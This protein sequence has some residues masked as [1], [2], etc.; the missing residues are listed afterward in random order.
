MI[1]DVDGN[2]QD[3]L[4]ACNK[5]HIVATT[6]ATGKELLR[7]EF[8]NVQSRLIG[9]SKDS[10]QIELVGDTEGGSQGSVSSSR[11]LNLLDIKTLKPNWS[12][13]L[14][15]QATHGTFIEPLRSTEAT[16]SEPVEPPLVS[17]NNI[18]LLQSTLIVPQTSDYRGEQVVAIPKPNPTAGLLAAEDPRW[19]ERVPWSSTTDAM[20]GRGNADRF[21]GYLLQSLIVCL[22]AV[23]F[24][25][26]FLRRML[27]RKRWS[28]KELFLF[29]LLFAVPYAVL[30]L[31]LASFHFNFSN[32]LAEGYGMRVVAARMLASLFVLPTVVFC[33]FCLK[34]LWRG[35]WR[36][37][38]M[39]SLI[40]IV[41]AVA[42]GAIHLIV[43]PALTPG[44]RY[45][46]WDWSHLVLVSYSVTTIGVLLIVFYILRSGYRFFSSLWNRKTVLQTAS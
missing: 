30:N 20:V 27:T 13:E 15:K 8:P 12:V 22:G 46:W 10:R 25:L 5:E 42:L 33:W 26:W 11:K 38:G 19:V 6:L 45:Q 16:S 17:V 2:G 7:A 18:R 28:L 31:N 9:L 35:H 21:V 44:S 29:P 37:L 36:R 40:A 34:C 41:I 3:E 14:P 39:V 23:L 32:Q 24:P 43:L 1:A 4:I